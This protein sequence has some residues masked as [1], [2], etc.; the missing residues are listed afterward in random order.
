MDFYGYPS[1]LKIDL[2]CKKT[3]VQPN[4]CSIEIKKL[5][6]REYHCQT[7]PPILDEAMLKKIVK[8]IGRYPYLLLTLAVF[9]WSGNFIVGRAVA[10]EIPP[11][12]MAFW[13]WT[14]AALLLL[15]FA[16][17]AIK[18]DWPQIRRNFPIL[19]LLSFLGV[20]SFNTLVYT[21]LQYTIAI[22]AFLLQSLMPVLIVFLSFLIL[23]DKINFFQAF[24]IAIS[25][26]GAFTIIVQGRLDI[27]TGL[28]LNQGDLLIALAVLSYAAYSVYLK[29]RPAISQLSLVTVIFLLGIFMLLPLYIWESLT[30]K[31]MPFYGVS[32]LAVAYI[33]IFPSIVSFFAFNRGVEMVG[34]N[35][36]GLFLHLMPVFGSVMAIFF[37]GESFQY[38]HGVGIFLI[39]SGIALTIFS[40]NRKLK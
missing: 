6:E 21:G 24:G 9:L 4:L 3:S 20:A 5:I 28:S 34:P 10:G 13:R 18:K 2:D 29:K 37:L 12:A 23:G 39:I 16:W 32:I 33:A 36:A 8:F 38:Y 1:K 19:L 27:L 17:T 40:S 35:Q 26:A 14:V 30:V 31:A 7:K 22:N 25:L 15:P 11:V